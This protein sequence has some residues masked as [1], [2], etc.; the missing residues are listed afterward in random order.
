MPCH[1]VYSTLGLFQVA[2]DVCC[3]H[4][5]DCINGLLDSRYMVFYSRFFFFE[6]KVFL[7]CNR[8]M[9]RTALNLLF[10]NL[11]Q[12][13][14]IISILSDTYLVCILRIWPEFQ[15]I[16]VSLLVV[17]IGRIRSLPM[18]WENDMPWLL[19]GLA[20]C[21]CPSHFTGDEHSSDYILVETF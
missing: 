5:G 1:Y 14:S 10:F 21:T 12:W 19:C 4:H 15:K 3:E 8:K 6:G 17:F 18:W 2:S 7:L 9:W 13:Q 11:Y 16:F 20:S